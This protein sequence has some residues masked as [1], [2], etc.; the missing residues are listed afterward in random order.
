MP[1]QLNVASQS[2]DTNLSE[3][4]AIVIFHVIAR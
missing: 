2:L 3:D 1:T 4:F